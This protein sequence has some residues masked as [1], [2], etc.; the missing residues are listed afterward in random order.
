MSGC[1]GPSN[2][3]VS[4]PKEVKRPEVKESKEKPIGES[5]GQKL[6]K[7]LGL[8]NKDKDSTGGGEKM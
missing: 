2:N 4:K 3:K 1:C 6:L 7:S 8:E 5:F